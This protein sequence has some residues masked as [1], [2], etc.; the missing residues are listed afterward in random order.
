VRRLSLLLVLSLAASPSAAAP[1]PKP[2]PKPVPAPSAAARARAEAL[3]KASEATRKCPKRGGGELC[4]AAAL[5][6]SYLAA[7]GRISEGVRLLARAH[8]GG[9]E[10]PPLACDAF[11]EGIGQ[12]R[13]PRRAIAC[14]LR[15]GEL[16]PSRAA[17][18]VLYGD[19]AARD[20]ELAHA[21]LAT[22]CNTCLMCGGGIEQHVTQVRQGLKPKRQAACDL[23]SEGGE[24]G[25]RCADLASLQE[26]WQLEQRVAPLLGK[27]PAARAA[28]AP[29]SRSF[30]VFQRADSIAVEGEFSGSD[31]RSD[32]SSYREK[33]E[34]ALFTETLVALVE[35]KLPAVD[36]KAQAQAERAL[37]LALRQR[38]QPAAK[39]AQRLWT[40][41]RGAWERFASAVDASTRAAVR[42]RVT[43]ARVYGLL[44]EGHSSDDAHLAKLEAKLKQAGVAD[45]ATKA[46]ADELR[47]LL[48]LDRKL[49]G[50]D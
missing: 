3:V 9:V 31:A 35:G 25:H 44:W 32:L 49:Y 27:R 4:A 15:A 20:P 2:K 22:N 47:R 48:K 6:T 26:A 17:L 11:A 21:L 34:A 8:D 18:M 42:L 23:L 24:C 38:T 10:V 1:T 28:L 39:K 45:A 29:L 37:G 40:A 16:E 50:R 14:Y 30:G 7:P 36:A 33:L 41:Y 13:D 43:L 19:G 46:V 12:P 5:G